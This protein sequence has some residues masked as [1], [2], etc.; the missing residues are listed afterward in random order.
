MKNFLIVTMMI[1]VI[2]IPVITFGQGGVIPE[3]IVV[4]AV[5]PAE[6]PGLWTRFWTWVGSL[7]KDDVVNVVDVGA[8][9]T[10]IPPPGTVSDAVDIT[11]EATPSIMEKVDNIGEYRE[12]VDQDEDTLGIYNDLDNVPENP[13]LSQRF[14]RW[15]NNIIK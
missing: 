15:L 10:G 11:K 3:R 14:F 9:A 6:E 13:T 1:M 8:E 12:N 4:T 2:F 5:A 7:T